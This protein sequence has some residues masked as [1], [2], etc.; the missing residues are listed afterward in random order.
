VCYSRFKLDLLKSSFIATSYGFRMCL[1]PGGVSPI[2]RQTPFLTPPPFF[3]LFDVVRTFFILPWQRRQKFGRCFIPSV[4][5]LE[6]SFYFREGNVCPSPMLSS[7]RGV[8]I[9]PRFPFLY[10]N[11]S[12]PFSPNLLGPSFD[13]DGRTRRKFFPWLFLFSPPR[14]DALLSGDFLV[15]WSIPTTLRNPCSRPCIV[16]GPFSFSFPTPGENSGTFQQL[17]YPPTE[18]IAQGTCGLCVPIR[19]GCLPLGGVIPCPIHV[20][21]PFWRLRL[22]R[23]ET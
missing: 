17:Y 4:F 19:G 7:A 8:D 21:C 15:G 22:L 13:I 20:I 3:V 6:H 5:Q 10:Q 12:L 18:A 23:K 1:R 14:R 9:L 16:A 11:A 2:T